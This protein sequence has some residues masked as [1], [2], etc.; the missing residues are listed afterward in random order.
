MDK[1]IKTYRQY[2]QGWAGQYIVQKSKPK[3]LFD[4]YGDNQIVFELDIHVPWWKRWITA[5]FLG[6]SWKKL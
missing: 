6:S 5:I 1:I 2:E 4:M 3:W